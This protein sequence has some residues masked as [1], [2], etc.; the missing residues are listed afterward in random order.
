MN[1]WTIYLVLSIV[2]LCLIG[3]IG[4][5][6]Y[7]AG[8]SSGENSVKTELALQKQEWEARIA[9]AQ[10]EVD[11]LSRDIQLKY[12]PEQQ[13]L[14]N[15]I[16]TL[17]KNPKVVTKYVPTDVKISEGVALW[18]DR[19]ARGE[20]LGM[21]FDGDASKESMYSMQNLCNTIAENYTN[22]NECMLKLKSL[23]SIVKTYI[24]QQE[25]LKQKEEK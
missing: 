1:Q 23:Q 5:Q 2:V 7:Q 10:L 20:N 4:Y 19:S 15:Q 13:K 14:K 17:K 8:Y 12:V 25:S 6:T 21:M 11:S 3:G 16:A 18:H 24:A 22:C 9:S